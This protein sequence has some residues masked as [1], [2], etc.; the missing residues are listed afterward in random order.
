MTEIIYPGSFNPITN[1]HIDLIKRAAKLF[2]HVH[3]AVGFNPLK[4]DQIEISTRKFFITEAMKEH[5]IDNVTVHSFDDMLIKM[6]KRL[7]VSNILRGIRNVTDFEYE[8]QI[9]EINRALDPTIE[10][11]FMAPSAN[12]GY[13]SSSMVRQLAKFDVYQ[14]EPFVPKIVY[15]HYQQVGC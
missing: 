9:L 6:C 3:I 14:L 11:V 7:N 10:S 4:K 12:L 1:G 2:T 13:V 15:E 5:G 8:F